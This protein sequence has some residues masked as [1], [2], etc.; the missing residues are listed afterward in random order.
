MIGTKK[1]VVGISMQLSVMVPRNEAS[2]GVCQRIV[3]NFG[4]KVADCVEKQVSDFAEH[5]HEELAI[6]DEDI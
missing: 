5:F 6:V 4:N 2:N 3:D 1:Q